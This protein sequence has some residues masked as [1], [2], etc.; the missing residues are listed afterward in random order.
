MTNCERF[1]QIDS[2]WLR[3]MVSKAE[4]FNHVITDT[5][6]MIKECLN[7]L[8]AEYCEDKRKIVKEM[9]EPVIE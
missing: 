5:S 2:E 3:M 1:E 9:D 8:Y 7:C 6:S 4:W